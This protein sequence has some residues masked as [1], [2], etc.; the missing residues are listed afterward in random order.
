[1]YCEKCTS[2]DFLRTLTILVFSKLPLGLALVLE[3]V[4]GSNPNLRGSFWSVSSGLGS[5]WPGIKQAKG[6]LPTN[7]S[8]ML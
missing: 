3:R 1:M 7:N 6:G 8:L 2:I 4:V 5:R